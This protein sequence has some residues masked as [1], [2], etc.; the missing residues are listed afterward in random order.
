MQGINHSENNEWW[1]SKAIWSAK[2]YWSCTGIKWEG[3]KKVLVKLP[4]RC[5]QEDLIVNNREIATAEKLK[6]WKYLDKLK[7]NKSIAEKN[8]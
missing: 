8:N 6:K 7:P 3:R 4:S 5:S 1:N 2:W